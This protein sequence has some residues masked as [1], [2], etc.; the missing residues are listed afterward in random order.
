MQKNIF[1]L[2]ILFVLFVPVKAQNIDTEVKNEIETYLTQ[3]IRRQTSIG[4]ITIDSLSVQKKKIQL[5]AKDNLSYGR[6]DKGLVDSIYTRIKELFPDEWKRYSIE[7][8]SDGYKI[9]DYIPL[10]RKERFEN[11]VDIPLKKNLSTP[12]VI[13]KG[14]QDRHLALWQSHGWYYEKSLTRWEWQRA[15]IFQTVE[16]LYT[17]SYVLPYLVPMLENAGANV[18]LPRERDTQSHEVIVDNESAQAGWSEGAGAGFAHLKKV[19]Y[20]LENPFTQ[21][22]YLQTKTVKK[23]AVSTYTWQPEIPEKGKYAVYISYASL[24]NSTKDARY[25]IYHTGGKTEFSINQTMGGGTWIFLGFFDFKEGL[26]DDCKIVLSNESKD[27]GRIVTADAVKIGG[28]MGNI[29]R[30]EGDHLETS[31]YPRYTEGARY[32]LQWAGVPDSV[33]RWTKG[34]R[35]YTDDYQSRGLWVN[36]MAGGSSN[37]PKKDG[38]HIPL[39]AVMAFHSDAGTT[40]NDSIIGT[41]GIC[42]THY[43]EEKFASG[44]PRILSRD[45]V[46]IIMDEIVQ[47][48]RLQY[49]PNWTRRQIWNKSYSE[50]RLPEAPTMLLELLSHQNFADMRYGLDPAF[51]FTVSRSIYKGFL[52]FIA[53]QYKFDYVVQPLPVHSFSTQFVGEA[54]VQLEWQSTE[55]AMEPTSAPTGYIVYTALG[56][57][58][59]DNGVFVRD[60][61]TTLSVEK[62][63][64]YRFKITAVNDGGES[65]PSEILSVCR[66]SDEKGLVLIVNGFDR[67]SAPDS[68]AAKDSI[69]GFLDFLDHGVPDKVQYNFIG[70]QYEFRRK[71]PWM[72]DDASGFGSSNANYE[73]SLIAGN[74]FD[75]PY[76]HGKSIVDAGYSFVSASSE[77]IM[78]G[79]IAL[80]D[81]RLTDLILGKQKQTR[82]GRG[83]FPSRFKTFPDD[84]QAKIT[85]YCRQGGNIFVSGAFVATDLWDNGEAKASDK[86]FVQD[87]LKYTWRTGHAAV[88]GK[89]KSVVSPFTQ[90]AGNYQFYHQLNPVFYAVESPDAIEPAGK[91]SYTIFRYS[92]NNL[93]A[94]VAYSGDYKTCILGFPFETLQKES[95]RNELMKQLLEFFQK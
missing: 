18:L 52:K 20:D 82:I 27:K 38:L 84:L 90:F 56:D 43:N 11:K 93:S 76:I 6:F 35:D 8:F 91:D 10:N 45:L 9:E 77:A 59:F 73:T 60:K 21:G 58:D 65:F 23:G 46:S 47:D 19:Y 39:D 69:A 26:N 63:K 42:M 89:V 57:N 48:I 41:L 30:G 55:E 74:T 14:L 81:Y 92:E 15:R 85:A 33:Y 80:N 87:I 24:P 64:L 54:Q 44:K 29:A 51:Q 86:A 62:D 50:A 32:W 75:Y 71:I 2:L 16:D 67:V 12:F 70:S 53:Y 66:K 88:T 3:T 36:Y 61:R 5:F 1:T 25:T 78:N 22:T 95:S 40:Y 83:A 7:L 68:F 79:Q 37:I 72:D 28:G 34:E 17:Q 4:K 13:K 94:G 31:G 49:E